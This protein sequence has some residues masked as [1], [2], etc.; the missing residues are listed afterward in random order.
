MSFKLIQI[1]GSSI[2]S[3]T[4]IRVYGSGTIRPNTV[5]EFSSSG[6]R[7][8]PASSGSTYT[9]VFGVALDY[10]EGASDAQVRVI[11][12]MPGQLWLADVA[13]TPATSQLFVRHAL[14]D[15]TRI[16]NT[17]TDITTGVFLTHAMSTIQ[18][19]SGVGSAMVGEFIRSPIT[20][21]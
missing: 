18:F 12:F 13:N 16:N 14:T 21:R 2:P 20:Q 5:V 8:V 6:N 10:I 17:S 15:F 4:I 1:K 19:F 7:V 9:N 11:P 3:P